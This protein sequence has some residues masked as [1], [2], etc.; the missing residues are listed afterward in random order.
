M[1]FASL[2]IPLYSNKQNAFL[3]PIFNNSKNNFEISLYVTKYK[4]IISGNSSMKAAL[5]IY[6]F[7]MNI[8][9]IRNKKYLW[10]QL[11]H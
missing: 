9:T 4:M 1:T 7:V 11:K 2:I 5:L 6:E 10:R 3:F 8:I